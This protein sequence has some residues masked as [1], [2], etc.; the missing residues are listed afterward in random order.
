MPLQ[1]S[2]QSSGPA[3][4]AAPRSAKKGLGAW[5]AETTPDEL[6]QLGLSWYYDWRPF[7]K[8]GPV[9]GVEFVPMFWNGVDVTP[10]NIEGILAGGAAH[11]L[12]FNE[13]DLQGQSNMTHEECLEL[14]PRL[15]ALDK[16]LGSPAPAQYKWLDGF[17]PEAIRRGYRV[18]FICLHRY[19]DI[20]NP[21]AISDVEGMIRETYAKYNLPIWLTES[22]A[23]DVTAWKQPQ[24]ATPTPAMAQAY[25]KGLVAMLERLPFVHRYAWFA[26]RVDNEYG[27]GSICHPHSPG[28]TLMG[29]IYRDAR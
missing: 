22:G 9:P 14:W 29:E 6:S 21:A 5:S 12:G 7:P 26:D 1:D 28:L 10:E 25:V 15:M 20:S 27:L 19:P 24:M 3:P 4:S 16:P 13:P 2:P 11:I 23:A 17:I 8:T 18:D